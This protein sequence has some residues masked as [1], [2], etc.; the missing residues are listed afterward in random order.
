MQLAIAGALLAAAILLAAK[1]NDAEWRIRLSVY[2]AIFNLASVVVQPFLPPQLGRTLAYLNQ[3]FAFAFGFF[4]AV[5][6]SL[7]AFEK[8]PESA[9]YA[10]IVVGTLAVSTFLWLAVGYGVGAMM[11]NRRPPD[12]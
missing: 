11:D 10:L 6:R 8:L 1:F 4:R 12:E 3:P 2:L 5:A 9:C 7:Y